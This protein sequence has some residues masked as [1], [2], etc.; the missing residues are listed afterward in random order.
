MTG[1]TPLQHAEP[2]SAIIDQLSKRGLTAEVL[3]LGYPLAP[4]NPFPAALLEV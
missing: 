3:A 1:G 4:E 2:L